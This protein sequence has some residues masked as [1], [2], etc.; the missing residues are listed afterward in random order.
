MI[1]NTY[2][3]YQLNQLH[4]KQLQNSIILSPHKDWAPELCSADIGSRAE[5]FVT[6]TTEAFGDLSSVSLVPIGLVDFRET[7]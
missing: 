5:Y 6:T 4:H 7:Q 3:I 2:I 1:R